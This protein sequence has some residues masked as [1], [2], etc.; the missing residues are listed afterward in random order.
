MR[1]ET[2]GDLEA[3]AAKVALPLSAKIHVT[4]LYGAQAS[5]LDARTDEDDFVSCP[6]PG[7]EHRHRSIRLVLSTDI[8]TD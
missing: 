2:W 1:I 5:E 3:F 4:A 7:C 8:C 6:R